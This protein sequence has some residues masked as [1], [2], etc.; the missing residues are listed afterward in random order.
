M[1]DEPLKQPGRAGKHEQLKTE[2]PE[3]LAFTAE[4]YRHFFEN[5]LHSFVYCRVL[6]DESGKMADYVYLIVNK[7]YEEMTGLQDVTGKKLS[8]VM[9]GLRASASVYLETIERVVLTGKPERFETFAEAFGK[10]FS[11]SLY[12]PEPGYFVAF[13]DNIT[14]RKEAEAK[15]TQLNRLYAFISQLNQAIVHVKDEKTLLSKACGIALEFGKFKIAWIGKTDLIQKRMVLQ[16]QAGMAPEEL[17]LFSSGSYL[18]GG[19]VAQVLA[20]GTSYISNDIDVDVT[21]ANPSLAGWKQNACTRGIRSI[22]ILPLKKEG[23]VT[24]TFHLYSSVHHF[25]D[26]EQLRLL[27][28]AAGN[29]S[30]AL[31][32]FE[33]EKARIEIKKQIEEAEKNHKAIFDNVSEG[34]VLLDLDCNIKAFNDKAKE[35]IFSNA[36]RGVDPGQS[37][38]EFMEAPRSKVL[39]EIMARVISGETIQYERFYGIR[40]NKP[41]WFS[42]TMNPVR[43]NEQ[44]TGVC[45]TGHDITEKKLA[46]QEREFDRNNLKSLINNTSDLMW[47]VDRDFKLITFNTAFQELV[48]RVSGNHLM[49]GTYVLSPSIGFDAERLKLFWEYYKRAFAGETFTEIEH[50]G[51]YWRETSFHPI[52]SGSEIIGT[53]CYSRD[54]TENKKNEASLKRSEAHLKSANRDLET[55]IYRASHDLRGPLSSIMGLTNVSR[56]EVS[57]KKALSYIDM[58]SISTKRL[59]DTLI[60]LVQTMALKDV[61][62]FEDEIDFKHMINET[63]GKFQFYE[64]FS[65]MKFDV[66]IRLSEPFISSRLILQPVIQN[67][68]E[69]SIKYQNLNEEH[70][71]T[72]I[73]ISDTPVE[74]HIVFEDNGIGMDKLIQDKVFDVYYKGTQSSKGSGLGL[75]IV[76][77][78][79]EKINGSIELESEPGKG[80]RFFIRLPKQNSFQ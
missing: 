5:M 76:K 69:N 19:P 8:E 43:E 80:S 31:D 36:D 16:E 20:T 39:K 56:L 70:P 10:W 60:G 21:I 42:F 3:N 6:F 50:P 68:I 66:G 22:A 2:H 9:P 34:F 63:F 55:F 27:E 14:E 61:A 71:T 59:D 7:K 45:I 12:S 35:Y 75:Y 41:S 53:A 28:E 77:T 49:A 17:Q 18:P 51:D 24:G 37:I 33:K 44:I 78:A 32:I 4:A 25:F 47:S 26:D 23:V 13:I 52:Y 62:K 65:R 57:D 30:F 74:L 67:L 38:Y 54:I 11:I 58:I 40:N 46:E 15:I 79:L 64:G 29:V 72:K 73:S 48:S 1:S